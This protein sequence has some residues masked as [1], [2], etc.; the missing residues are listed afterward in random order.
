M[1]PSRWSDDGIRVSRSRVYSHVIRL[2]NM[3]TVF[4]VLTEEDWAE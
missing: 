3:L 1:V 2:I 4:L